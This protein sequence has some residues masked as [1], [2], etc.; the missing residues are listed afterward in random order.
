VKALSY[1]KILRLTPV[2]IIIMFALLVS[3]GCSTSS[4][5]QEKDDYLAKVNVI[6][7]RQGVMDTKLTEMFDAKNY[8][9]L[10]TQTAS[11]AKSCDEMATEL[12]SLKT[13]EQFADGNKLLI[14]SFNKFSSALNLYSDAFKSGDTMNSVMQEKLS[15]AVKE[16]D[17][18][19]ADA[20]EAISM[21]N[22]AAK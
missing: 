20:N 18:A 16:Y 6:I 4:D 17:D 19:A 8:A 2:L 11:D 9:A 10:A 15:K 21:I 5:K 13:P 14:T 3:A 1:P 12:T 7:D 22:A